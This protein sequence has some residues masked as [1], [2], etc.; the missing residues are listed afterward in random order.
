MLEDYEK[1]SK[2]QRNLTTENSELEREVSALHERLDHAEKARRNEVT[3]IKMRY[4][5]QMNTMREELKSLQNQVNRP[6][7]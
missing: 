4:E 1:V 5:S 3:D 6:Y 7:G 2:I